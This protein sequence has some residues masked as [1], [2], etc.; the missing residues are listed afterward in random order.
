[1]LLSPGA[2]WQNRGDVYWR[3]RPR[4]ITT[5]LNRHRR[6]DIACSGFVAPRSL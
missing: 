2:I 6:C 5:P 1:V 3:S 4:H